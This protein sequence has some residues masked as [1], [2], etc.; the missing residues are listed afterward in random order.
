MH[1]TN[2]G[3][4]GQKK[5][6]SS[7]STLHCQKRQVTFIS[8]HLLSFKAPYVG[9]TIGKNF[10]TRT[11]RLLKYFSFETDPAAFISHAICTNCSFE[12]QQTSDIGTFR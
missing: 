10:I 7:G 9:T 8:S 2:S 5:L 11:I 1:Q 6:F 3:I 4:C 12:S